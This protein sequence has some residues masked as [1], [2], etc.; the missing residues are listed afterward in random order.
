MRFHWVPSHYR[1]PFLQLSLL[2]GLPF[3]F[4]S[5]STAQQQANT[6][7]AIVGELR[8]ARGG[9]L[10]NNVLVVLQRSGAQV[11]IRYAD[12]EGKFYF[13]GLPGNVYHV[14][15]QEKGFQPLDMAVNVNPVVQHINYMYAELVP[16]EGQ[17]S[18]RKTNSD[19]KGSNPAMVD[20]ASL[21][22][23]FPKEAQK[24]YEKAMQLQQ[25]G[26]HQSAIEEYKKALSIAPNM[27]FARNNLG[28]LYLQ[29][30][31]F[32]NAESEFRTVIEGN[33][34]DANA[35]FNLGNVYLLTKR[36]DEATDLIQQGITREPQSAFGHFLMGS[37]MLQKGKP[38]EAE[39]QLRAALEEDPSIANAHLALANL[40]L[41]QNR[42]TEVVEE[43]QS[44]LRQ[45]PD[46]SYAPQARE[47]LKKLRHEGPPR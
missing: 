32:E 35:Y 13:E 41:K 40:Y 11:G 33:R 42:N 2:L 12:G 22:S 45:S 26:K 21:L 37:V 47:L 18:P 6:D 17:A 9:I 5:N 7:G 10:P 3:L 46:S 24:R 14:V 19:V 25:R 44:F 29:D 20:P 8:V 43:L 27:Y 28:S 34:A 23:H 39:K 31:Q 38:D 4:L 30:Q 1:G 36:L 16:T 15:I